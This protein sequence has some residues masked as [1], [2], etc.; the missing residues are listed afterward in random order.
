[1][2]EIKVAI[3]GL[4]NCASS[5]IQG[6]EY[7]KNIDDNSGFIPGIMHNYF[8]NYRIKD[9]K[10]VAA[11]DVN[12]N[13]VGKDLS[14]AIFTE[15]NCTLKFCEVPKTGI[16]V[17]K[18][19]LLD[20]LGENLKKIVPV[21]PHQREENVANILRER[22]VDIL[23]NYLP[24]G[25]MKA[26]EF[27][28]EQALIAGCGFINAIPELIASNPE[29]GLKFKNQGL[30]LAGDDIKSQIGATIVNRV[31]IDMCHKR[32]VKVEESYQLNLA[33]NTDFLNFLEPEREKSKL[34]C[35]NEALQSQIPYKSSI[36]VAL[37]Y[38]ESQKDNKICYISLKGINFGG[39]PV[40]IDLKM[41]VE[42]SPN[43][44]GIMVDA[45]RA[46][47]IALDN[48]ISGSLNDICAY[49]FKNPPEQHTDDEAYSMVEKFLSSYKILNS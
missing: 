19:H 25:S 41:S 42:D 12:K 17:Q 38:I 49:Y 47:K 29:W 8:G 35:K 26:S 46:M 20:G 14:E 9:I 24:T 33:G 34:R 44:A 40:T 4:G 3:A 23:I 16:K 1:M 43:S 39:A 28:A 48:G 2:N 30:P 11:F 18:G 37:N 6:I 7:Y 31:L 13:K 32:G 36:G 15:P 5:L 21:D 22:N 45:I 27:Y 10:I